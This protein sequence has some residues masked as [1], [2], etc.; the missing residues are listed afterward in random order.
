MVDEPSAPLWKVIVLI[1]I[2]F[3]GVCSI[4]AVIVLAMMF[5]GEAAFL[6]IVPYPL[7]ALFVFGWIIM[8]LSEK[9]DV[10]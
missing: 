5:L 3:I 7:F 9:L 10:D 6:V 8:K 2:M 1:S 4:P